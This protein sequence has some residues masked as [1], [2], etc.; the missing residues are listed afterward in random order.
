MKK[1]SKKSKDNWEKWRDFVNYLGRTNRY[2][3]NQ[4]WRDFVENDIV[5]SF[6]K[7]GK[8]IQKNNLFWRARIMSELKHYN[9]HPNPFSIREICAPPPGKNIEG[10]INP[11]GI[12]YLYLADSKKTAIA[13]VRPFVNMLITLG[14]FGLKKDIKVIDATENKFSRNGYSGK[15]KKQGVILS[16]QN[17]ELL[18]RS[19]NLYFSAPTL[20][21][22]ISCLYPATQYLSELIKDKGYKGIKYAS[23]GN[24]KGYNLALFEPGLAGLKE[25]LVCQITPVR[26]KIF[27][28]YDSGS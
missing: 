21:N 17:E 14:K 11:R 27:P 6:E 4:Q 20:P 7:R 25:R 24:P 19:I 28:D 26:Y 18:W 5:A 23:S 8:I 1:I 13:E 22:D 15:N 3:L 10:R 12:S 9:E 16:K 2:V